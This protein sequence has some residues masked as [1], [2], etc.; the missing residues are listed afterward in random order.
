[1]KHFEVIVRLELLSNGWYQFSG[2]KH[3]GEQSSKSQPT[4]AICQI[5]GDLL[6][7]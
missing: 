2:R 5:A 7:Q 6:P 3:Y 1:M 4:P